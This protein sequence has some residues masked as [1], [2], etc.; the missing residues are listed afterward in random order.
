MRVLQVNKFYHPTVGGVE[1]VVRTLAEG[2]RDRGHA[3]RVL[4][5]TERGLGRRERVDGVPVTR[6]TSPG[7][8]LSVPLAPTFPL[9]LRSLAREADLVHYH[10]PNPLAVVGH[11]LAVPDGTPTV[12]TY[13]SDIVR[14]SL[15]L[16]LYRPALERCLADVDHVIATSPRLRD[17]SRFLAPHREKCSVVPLSV[18]AALADA[19]ETPKGAETDDR[20]ETLESARPAGGSTGNGGWQA[21]DRVDGDSPDDRPVVLCVGRLNYYKGVEY[22]VE[23]MAGVDARLV[24]VGDGDRRARLESR[25]RELGLD[26]R[27]PGR[28]DD[29]TLAAWYDR[30]DVFVLPSVEP[31]E[32]FG[33]VQLEAMARGLP[34]VN[35]DLPTGVPWVSRDGETGV[36]VPPRDADALAAALNGLL[37]D[38]D[39]RETYGENGRQ[40]VRERFTRERM[41]D[42]TV[43]VYESVLDGGRNRTGS[44]G[45]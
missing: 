45:E 23:A 33:I 13:H 22:L 39:L 37:A 3:T 38:P 20:S 27:F 16:R 12:L 9:R 21:E 19:A 36:T 34:V 25:A 42:D 24:V 10:L 11:V 30:A 40:R 35:T 26:A 29:A 6:V 18:P 8:A 14:Q 1:R 43:A 32:A 7:M 28:V 15:A 5:A 31:S 2:L 44:A 41:L 17:N 4:A